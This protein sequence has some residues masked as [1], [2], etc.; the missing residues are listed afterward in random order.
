MRLRRPIPANDEKRVELEVERLWQKYGPTQ[1][2]L[3]MRAHRNHAVERFTPL[4]SEEVAERMQERL[5]IWMNHYHR[6]ETR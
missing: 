6:T 5:S 1:Y 2:V 4:E 3:M